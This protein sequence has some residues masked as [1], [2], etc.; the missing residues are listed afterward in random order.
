MHIRGLY[1]ERRSSDTRLLES[2]LLPDELV[3]VGRSLALSNGGPVRREHVVPRLFIIEACHAM[4]ENG[5]SDAEVAAFIR[6]HIKVVLVTEGEAKK[7]DGRA[8]LNLK[9]TMP[10]DW[11]F[12]DDLFKRLALAEIDWDPDW[13]PPLAKSKVRAGAP[14]SVQAYLAAWLSALKS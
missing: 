5:Q 12:G 10:E 11:A 2:L 14:A 6:D 8:N 1:E 13:R 4:I 7:M 3:V 9:Q